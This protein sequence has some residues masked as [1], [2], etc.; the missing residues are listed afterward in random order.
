MK[1]KSKT[2]NLY[3]LMALGKSLWPGVTVYM[4]TLKLTRLL[5]KEP[6]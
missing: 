2:F 1:K 4:N 3:R 5:D 6:G